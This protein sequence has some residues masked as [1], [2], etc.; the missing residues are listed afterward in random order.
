MASNLLYKADILW[1]RLVPSLENTE[2]CELQP[3]I[4]EN[5][6]EPIVETSRGKIR[7]IR[8]VDDATGEYRVFS[9]IFGNL[10]KYMKVQLLV[11][12][13]QNLKQIKHEIQCNVKV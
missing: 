5:K 11:A 12:P 9:N 1:N 10:K 13:L 2:T 7:G 8:K 4:P 3:P 6:A